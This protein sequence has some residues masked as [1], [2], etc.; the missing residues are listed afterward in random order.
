MRSLRSDFGIF[1]T[2]L[3]QPMT[4]HD[5]ST[6]PMPPS[7]GELFRRTLGERWALLH[8][9]IQKRFEKNPEVG[10]RLHYTGT[11]DA[12]TASPIG[13]V[14]AWLSRPLIGGALIPVVDHDVPVDIEVFSKLGHS[15]IFKKRIYRL[16]GRPPVTFTSFMLGNARGEVFEHVGAGLGMTLRL[17]VR[18]GHL[19][20]QS[21]RYFL[22]VLGLRLPIP[23][24]LTPGKTDLLHQNVGP[25]RFRIRIEIN[26][27]I[28]GTT[29]VQA[30]EFREVVVPEH[31]E[32]DRR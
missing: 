5:A 32:G 22:A 8:P 19:H 13:K 9:D 4:H 23:G 18:E 2:R 16:N 27:P 6:Q 28:F 12:L 30:G 24:L 10:H 7:E 31:A 20:F 17:D 15:A 25:D 14:I 21:G 1:L 11:L 29:F 3:A 26:H